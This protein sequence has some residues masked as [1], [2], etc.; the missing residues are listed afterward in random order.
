MSPE[1]L[2]IA[3]D[4][5]LVLLVLE[6]IPI[7]ALLVFAAYYVSKGLGEFH[8]KASS[9]LRTARMTV[10]DASNTAKQAVVTGR[11]PIIRLA[12]TA[13]GVRAGLVRYL[14]RR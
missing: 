2:A 14:R 6:A 10:Q 1:T 5:A 11:Q 8:P 9:G 3:R 4:A 7:I 12:S 13:E